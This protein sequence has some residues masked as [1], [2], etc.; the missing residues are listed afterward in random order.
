MTKITRAVL[1]ATSLIIALGGCSVTR[2]NGGTD[3]GAQDTNAPGWT[4]RTLVVGSHSTVADDAQ[5]TYLQ[6]KWGVSPQL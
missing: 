1:S 2:I 4:G 3:Q 5:A 6:Q